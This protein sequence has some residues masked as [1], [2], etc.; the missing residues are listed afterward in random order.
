MGPSRR[1]SRARP[2]GGK[3][4]WRR[5]AGCLCRRKLEGCGSGRGGAHILSAPSPTVCLGE[6]SSAWRT[7]CSRDQWRSRLHAG[8]G[9]PWVVSSR[10]QPGPAWPS[11]RVLA[12]PPCPQGPA[13]RPACPSR[14]REGRESGV[15]DPERNIQRLGVPCHLLQADDSVPA[16][17]RLGAPAGLPSRRAPERR[18][19]ES[20]WAL[21]PQLPPPS[22]A[23]V[24]GT[25]CPPPAPDL[26]ETPSPYPEPLPAAKDS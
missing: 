5:R 14:V 18:P 13:S 12:L 7:Q 19:R 8:A 15:D 22:A 1:G 17:V 24:G 3:A 11:K 26:A 16:R 4:S 21:S 25:S 2:G 6:R 20:S 9:G 23:G 10:Q